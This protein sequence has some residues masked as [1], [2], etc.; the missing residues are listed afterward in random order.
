MLIATDSMVLSLDTA[1]SEPS[2]LF[3]GE[4]IARVAEGGDS[5]VIAMKYGDLIVY[6]GKESRAV[7][8]G[9]DAPIESLLILS[10]NPLQLL[11]GTEGPYLYRFEDGGVER[12][13]SFDNLECRKEWHTPWGGPAA[14]RSMAMTS[15]GWVYADI[16]V[17]SIMRSPDSGIT[18]QPV[19]PQL[20]E[21]VHQVATSVRVNERVYANTANAVYVSNDRGRSWEHRSDGFPFRYGRAI[22]VHPDDPDSLLATVSRGPHGNAQGELYR[23]ADAGRSWVHVTA[24]FPESAPGNID[25]CQIGFA[26]D[27]AAWGVVERTLYRSE[28]GGTRWERFWEASGDIRMIHSR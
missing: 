13:E 12:N 22:A 10:P 9:I 2:V 27:G 23:S 8:T 6:S 14:L 20:H 19:T 7:S 1:G 17:G 28:D 18:W 5:S 15:D 16:H 11:I 3:E 24:G 26:Q 25:T 21:D 4:G